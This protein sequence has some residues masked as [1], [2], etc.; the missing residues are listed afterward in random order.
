MLDEK[1]KTFQIDARRRLL[2]LGGGISLLFSAL[3]SRLF[4]LQLLKSGTFRDM[5]DDNRIS[6]QLLP[7]S[8]G[9]IF[10]RNGLLLVENHPDYQL[11]AIPEMATQHLRRSSRERS[12]LPRLLELLKPLLQL[13]EKE[14]QSVLKQ[15]SRQRAF[16]PVTVKTHLTWEEVS[17]IETRVHELPGVTIEVQPQRHYRMGTLASHAIGYLGEV[18]EKDQNRFVDIDFRSGDLLG[19]SGVERAM[20]NQ[21]RGMDGL[22]EIEVNAYGRQVREL[23]RTP[24][25]PGQDITLTLDMDL[26]QE[27]ERALAESSGGT[28]AMVMMRPHSG[29]LLVMASQPAY[30]PNQF[31]NGF[32]PDEWRQLTQD[33]N[34]PLTNK[35]IQGQY[36]PG[37][38]F[39]M[40]VVLAALRLGKLHEHDTIYCPGYTTRQDHRFYCWKLR[41]HG[42]VSLHQAIAQ[43]CDVFFYELADRVGIDAIH[44][45]ALRMGL[46][47]LTGIALDGERAGLIPSR[48]WK[49]TTHKAGWY[50]GETLI[51]AIGQGY[52]LST[53]MQLAVMISAIAN[54]GAVYRPFL[55]KSAQPPAIPGQKPG[56][57]GITPLWH[58]HFRPEHI[59]LI[60]AGLEEVVH[61]PL[62]TARTA[63]LNGVRMAG[64]TGTSQVARHRRTQ[65]GTLVKTT[66]RRLMDHAMF[67]AYAPAHQPEIAISVIVEHGG[68]GG[69]NA[70]PVAKRVMD[71]Y[72]AKQ[73]GET[74]ATTHSPGANPI[75][76]NPDDE[77][78]EEPPDDAND[79]P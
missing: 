8:R 54:G 24:P 22:R 79:N 44:Q 6:L 34:R 32:L 17:L 43:S 20:E 56:P 59:A 73:R 76:P 30:D 21:L 3:T 2:V 61:G 77:L 52:V 67:V 60:H 23:R 78:A 70:A 46:G 66:N 5:A 47:T 19:K 62:G 48:A 40:V 75:L 58:N 51:T 31:I 64:K 14:I 69:T 18:T 4:Y 57:A 12:G 42:S 45:Q 29:E 49:R 50:P 7:A 74:I 9:R 39:K 38:T 25:R 27:A 63:K 53:P 68:G 1:P 15:A 72:F 16:M 10:D 65:S 33:P 37:S 36:P 71:L 35:A 41:G 55:V 26:Q 13:E 28:G 11:V